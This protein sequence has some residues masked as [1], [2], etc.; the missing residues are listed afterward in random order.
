MS[1]WGYSPVVVQGL[2][3]IKTVGMVFAILLGTMI[4]QTRQVIMAKHYEFTL[5]IAA[6][7]DNTHDAW[8]EAVAAFALD[9]GLPPLAVCSDE[10]GQVLYNEEGCY[11]S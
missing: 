4:T 6:D 9:P 10:T 5:T 3:H 1:G 11:S 2:T 8:L 7:S